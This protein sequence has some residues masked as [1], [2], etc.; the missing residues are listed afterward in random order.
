M[1]G[2]INDP[3]KLAPIFKIL[4]AEPRVLIIELLKDN[5]LCVGALATRL[6]ISQGAV[7]QHLR[8]LRDANLVIP[9]KR[10]YFTHYRLN[11]KTLSKWTDAMA[12]LFEPHPPQEPSTACDN[13]EKKGGD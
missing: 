6:D 5:A 4:S 7:S 2:A 13:H 10:G 1:D 11:E 12:R 3:E 9:E 8:I